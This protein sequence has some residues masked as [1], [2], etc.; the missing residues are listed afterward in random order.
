MPVATE[1]R[2]QR[3]CSL[4]LEASR[5]REA[6]NGQAAEDEQRTEK[7]ERPVPGRVLGET[8]R[9]TGWVAEGR[10]GHEDA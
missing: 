5:E 4:R 7:V 8:R 1:Y 9:R 3:R 2:P 10:I 6:G